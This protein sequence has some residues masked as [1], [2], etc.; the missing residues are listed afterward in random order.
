MPMR[1]GSD[2]RPQFE[3]LPRVHFSRDHRRADLAHLVRSGR[4]ARIRPGAYVEVPPD[5]D[6]HARRRFLALARVVAAAEQLEVDH[7][8]SHA[9]AA[10]V[11]GLAL[12]RVPTRTHLIQR[13]SRPTGHGADDLVRHVHELALAHRT[14]RRGIPVTDLD[15]TLVDC[16]MALDPLD[17]LVVADSALRAG[18]DPERCADLL[19]S[20]P[21]RRGV[22]QARAI[23]EFADDG[24]ESPR[25]TAVRYTV[26]Q[27]GMPAP[28]TQIRID[29]S[30]GEYW[31]DVGW[32]D[33][34]LLVEYDGLAKY[35]D[36]STA[37]RVLLRERRRQ[38]AVQEQGW[39]FLRLTGEDV[40]RSSQVM[41][42]LTP[43]LPPTIANT[44][45]PRVDLN[46]RPR[47]SRSREVFPA[48]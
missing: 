14:E 35:G 38:D 25:E 34:R 17:A 15:R 24:A 4:L 42:R 39:R 37:P 16:A 13:V 27:A 22:R 7:T 12:W 33:L 10:L 46:P 18:A 32:P 28:E 36:G 26:L 11:W 1:P 20:M 21:G 44:L 19:A 45:T 47:Q 5:L 23:V 2:D 30:I 8:F 31:A 3:P 9:T 48:P 41:R 6:H 40:G 29:T 43:L